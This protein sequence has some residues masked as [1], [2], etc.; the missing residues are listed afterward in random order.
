M[1]AF[2]AK[3]TLPADLQEECFCR[4]HGAIRVSKVPVEE[5]EELFGVFPAFEVWIGVIQLVKPLELYPCGIDQ[6][7]RRKLS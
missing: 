1:S 3:S 6:K 4:S 7:Q 2:Y 5:A